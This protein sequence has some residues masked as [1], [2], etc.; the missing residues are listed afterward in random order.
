VS[1]V[2]GN[3]QTKSMKKVAGTLKIAQAQYRE[4]EAFSKYSS[5]MDAISMMTLDKGRKNT[6]LLIQP[7]HAVMPVERQ[8]AV[9][10]CGTQALM[11][12]IPLEKVPD[13]EQLLLEN[14]A[15]GDTFDR[16][17]TEGISADVEAA[18]RSAAS[19]VCDSILNN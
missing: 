3:A 7:L 5:D 11:K 8:V 4:L 12:D 1:R 13:F 2:G 10:Y 16:I 15:A 9:L 17:R 19:A 18:I 14:L 6:R